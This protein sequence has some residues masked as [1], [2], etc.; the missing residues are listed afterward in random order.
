MIPSILQVITRLYEKEKANE[1][2]SLPT[3]GRNKGVK[4]YSI[5]KV[6]LTK[7]YVE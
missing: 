4:R 5:F 3:G 2:L 6:G 7:M 1:P